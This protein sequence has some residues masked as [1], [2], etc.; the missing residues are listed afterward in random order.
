LKLLIYGLNFSPELTGIGKYS[1][2][3]ALW[4]AAQ[5]HDVRVV[6]APPFYPEWRVAEGFNGRK[7]ALE[8]IQAADGGRLRIVRC[9][10]WVP[11][12][13][14]G[15]TRILHL[16][17][18]A[19]SSVPSLARHIL[20]R[21]DVVF[22]VEP[23][24]FS[25]P[26]AWVA[27]RLC[28]AKAWLHIQDFELD[29]GVDL[30]L[31][32]AGWL[33]R[34][35]DFS[36]QT[37]MRR[38]DRVSTI[39]KRMMLKLDQKNVPT[40]LQVLFPNWVNTKEICPSPR[41]NAL[42]SELGIPEGKTVVLYSGN[43]GEKQ[44]LEIVMEAARL[45]MNEPNLQFVMCGTGAAFS[46]IFSIGKEI[47]NIMW[48]PLQ[49]V[50]RL[51]ELLAMGDIHLLPQR[52]DAADLVMPS[53]LLGIMASGRPVVATAESGTEISDCVA[54]RG[55]SVE[56]EDVEAFSMAI[57]RLVANRSEREAFGANARQ[58]AVAHF[59]EE[60]VLCQFEVELKGLV[61]S[62]D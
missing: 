30:G 18:F 12:Q 16:V 7:Y 60:N 53:K 57:R 27:A 51:N 1:G 20:W 26:A 52:R 55:I 4:L 3:M 58:F 62:P 44:G 8:N 13:P 43:M 10:V 50:E 11:R 19:L 25:A 6:T 31:I 56:P 29:A 23:T 42:R 24:V 34:A 17:S 49:P 59:G 32:R 54:G 38:F 45:L 40:R 61:S 15:V 36:D 28:G 48:L 33:K 22:T 14:R 47:P 37:L 21:P 9:P 2:E 39:S 41:V 35:I 46:R 5:G